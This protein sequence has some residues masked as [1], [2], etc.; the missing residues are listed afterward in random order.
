MKEDKCDVRF[1]LSILNSIKL[2]LRKSSLYN[3]NVYLYIPGKYICP[4]NKV[5]ILGK[6]TLDQKYSKL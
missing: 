3:N 1:K 2:L 4:F 6:T 5:L